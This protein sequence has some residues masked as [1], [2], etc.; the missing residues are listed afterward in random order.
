MFF[1]SSMCVCVF[2]YICT[3]IF[4]ESLADLCMYVYSYVDILYIYMDMLSFLAI[5]R[6]IIVLLLYCYSTKY[7]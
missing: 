1:V 3:I 4:I 5:S 6:I 2:I 7:C